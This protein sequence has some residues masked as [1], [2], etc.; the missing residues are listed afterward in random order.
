MKCPSWEMRDVLAFTL[1]ALA[2]GCGTSIGPGPNWIN[3]RKTSEDYTRSVSITHDNRIYATT[4]ALHNT[5]Q[6][7]RWLDERDVE[8]WCRYLVIPAISAARSDSRE[9]DPSH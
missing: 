9:N 4:V 6:D 5:W 2:N 7:K 3:I 1:H 8:A